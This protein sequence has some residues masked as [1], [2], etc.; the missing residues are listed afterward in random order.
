MLHSPHQTAFVIRNF[1]KPWLYKESQRASAAAHALVNDTFGV[2]SHID[3]AGDAVRHAFASAYLKVNVMRDH[4]L[5]QARAAKL[6]HNAGVAHELDGADNPHALSRIMDLANNGV[7]VELVGDGRLPAAGA[8]SW[9]DAAQIRDRVL[10]T[11][12]TGGLQRI[13]DNNTL[14]PT[15]VKDILHA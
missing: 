6:V 13:G 11:L 7:G 3:D 12:R 1:D 8:D 4:G 2:G 9:L 15:S 14:I 5:T 10:S